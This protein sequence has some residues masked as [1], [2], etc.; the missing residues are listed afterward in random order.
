M[1]A[2]TNSCIECFVVFPGHWLKSCLDKTLISLNPIRLTQSWIDVITLSPSL[3]QLSEI[4]PISMCACV[5]GC[6]SFVIIHFKHF[7]RTNS[8]FFLT[9]VEHWLQHSP[10]SMLMCSRWRRSKSC[11]TFWRTQKCV[12]VWCSFYFTLNKGLWRNSTRLWV[13]SLGIRDSIKAISI[14]WL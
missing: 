4:F 8:V 3:F 9:I 10:N 6:H 13:W 14:H 5:Q 11:V 2:L 1:R 12:V 7:S